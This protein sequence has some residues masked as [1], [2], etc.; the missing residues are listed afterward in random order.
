M[1]VLGRL[2][3][4]PVWVTT[5]VRPWSSSRLRRLR[6][7]YEQSKFDYDYEGHNFTTAR[8]RKRF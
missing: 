8:T 7:G 5:G 4:G 1:N 2:G 3:G 6:R